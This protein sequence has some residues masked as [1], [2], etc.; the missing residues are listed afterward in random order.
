MEAFIRCYPPQL[1]TANTHVWYVLRGE[2]FVVDVQA[3]TQPLAGNAHAP[4]SIAIQ[5]HFPLGQQ[6]QI[7]VHAAVVAA[8]CELSEGLQTVNLRAMM[9]MQDVRQEV[10]MAASYAKQLVEFRTLTR[11]VVDVVPPIVLSQTRGDYAVIPVNTKSFRQS[12]L[13]SSS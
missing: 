8:D 7:A 9:N 6:G 10:V 11:F 1:P 3:P 12:V 2:E 13:P 4:H 5:Q